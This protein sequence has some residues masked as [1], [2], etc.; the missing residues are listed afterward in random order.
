MD[1]HPPT[2][3]KGQSPDGQKLK[4]KDRQV[5]KDKFSVSVLYVILSFVISVVIV[6]I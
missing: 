4:D 6:L 5:I 2:P 3:S 1:V